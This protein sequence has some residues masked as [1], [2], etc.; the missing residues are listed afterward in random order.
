M[1]LS[2]MLC[3]MCV[4]IFNRIYMKKKKERKI[5]QTTHNVFYS[6]FINKFPKMYIK[7]IKTYC[8]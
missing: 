7:N 6:P 1:H 2:S 8:V 5:Y 3:S 4:V